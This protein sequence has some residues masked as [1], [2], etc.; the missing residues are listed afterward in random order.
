MSVKDLRAKVFGDLYKQIDDAQGRIY[1]QSLQGQVIDLQNGEG[2][3]EALKKAG[4]KVNKKLAALMLKVGRKEALELE[5]KFRGKQAFN[6]IIEKFEKN[7]STEELA[8]TIK[9][10]GLERD[11]FLVQRFRSKLNSKKI[12]PGIDEITKKMLEAALSDKMHETTG[13]EK[14]LSTEIHEG[15]KS[16]RQH[17]TEYLTPPKPTTKNPEK[18]ETFQTFLDFL[19]LRVV[20][21]GHGRFG[22]SV[23]EQQAALGLAYIAEALEAPEGTTAQQFGQIIQ[24]AVIASVTEYNDEII[25][26]K[27]G[28]GVVNLTDKELASIKEI[29]INYKQVATKKGF[30]GKYTPYI[31]FQFAPTNRIDGESE[32]RIKKVILDILVPKLTN[33]DYNLLNW[34]GSST[35]KEKIEYIVLSEFVKLDK[36]KNVK[37]NLINGKVELKTGGE[38]S[39]K[40]KPLKEKSSTKKT[41]STST[42]KATLPKL[43]TAVKSTV[44]LTALLPILNSRIQDTVRSN[45][46]YPSLQNRSGRFASSVRITD[47][48][49]TRQGFPSIGFTYQKNPY[50]IFEFPGG[51]PNRATKER[52]PRTIIDKSIREIAAELMQARFYTR[53][54]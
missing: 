2:I 13:F 43:D 21:K 3:R 51:D 9:R 22:M 12:V 47:I 5:D 26:S 31:T 15:D 40:Y 39:K 36:R 7:K 33:S 27:G 1:V 53:R 32:A 4:I 41:K 20:D 54:V 48:V 46:R 42:T 10:G 23:A 14:Y 25:K 35:A 34:S 29:G 17:Y 19:R 49:T 8:K 6:D 37:V 44:D 18:Q 50:Q 28:K 38:D 45:M 16:L 11:Q 52:D 24:D 30:T